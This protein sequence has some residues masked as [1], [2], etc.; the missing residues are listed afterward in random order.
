MRDAGVLMKH[1]ADA[2][3]L[4][5]PRQSVA[6]N[7]DLGDGS[8]AFRQRSMATILRSARRRLESLARGYGHAGDARRAQVVEQARLELEELSW[9]LDDLAAG[10]ADGLARQRAAA[11][12]LLDRLQDRLVILLPEPGTSRAAERG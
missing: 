10:A 8:A 2:V 12:V 7:A 11:E 9:R 3:P 6:F 1:P 5:A 4:D